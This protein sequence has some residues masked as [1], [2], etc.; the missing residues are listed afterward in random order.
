MPLLAIQMFLRIGNTNPALKEL[1]RVVKMVHEKTTN[2][3][4]FLNYFTKL[5][6]E[7]VKELAANSQTHQDLCG[8]C[9]GTYGKTT[10][11]YKNGHS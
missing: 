5:H 11:S 8:Y 3:T 6:K 1:A 4:A 7:D 9:D 2:P 10:L